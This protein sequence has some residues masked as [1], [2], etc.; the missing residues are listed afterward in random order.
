VGRVKAF[1]I[2]GYEIFFNS[3]DHPPPHIHVLKPGQW[4]IKV[5]FLLC[6]RDHLEY[7]VVFPPKPKLPATVKQEL[8]EQVLRHRKKLL[9]EWEA[10]VCK[11]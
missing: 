10:K 8:L 5:S 1:A 4:M 3:S 7:K 2:A 6:S 11:K 9:V